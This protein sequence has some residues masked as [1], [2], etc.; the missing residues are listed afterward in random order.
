V[1]PHHQASC[2]CHL[3]MIHAI[4][5]RLSSTRHG[6]VGSRLCATASWILHH[7]H[8]PCFEGCSLVIIVPY[9]AGGARPPMPLSH[10]LESRSFA[11]APCA[12]ASSFPLGAR[13]RSP[14][15]SR[16][17]TPICD[18]ATGCHSKPHSRTVSFQQF[19]RAPFACSRAIV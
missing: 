13:R 15:S 1:T 9:V 7:R 5:Y 12:T 8:L 10:D 14:S 16:G 2:P 3:A 17:I 18:A 6:R 4:G 11:F 19:C